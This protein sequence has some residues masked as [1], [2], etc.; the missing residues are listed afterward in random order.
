MC[1]VRAWGRLRAWP[2]KASAPGGV[3]WGPSGGRDTGG[4]PPSSH[5]SVLWL[6]LSSHAASA[7]LTFRLLMS[8]SGA[9]PALSPAAK[10]PR[11]RSFPPEKRSGGPWL[12]PRRVTPPEDWPITARRPQVCDPAESAF[13]YGRGDGHVCEGP[14]CGFSAAMFK[15]GASLSSFCGPHV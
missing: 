8:V 5:P 7:P 13:T 12:A 14:P 6:S 3:A 11:Q 2:G 1:L 4:D 15:W 9:L 10:A